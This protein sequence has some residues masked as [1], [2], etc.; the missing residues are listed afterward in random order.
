MEC[1]IIWTTMEWVIMEGF[2]IPKC[3]R[4]KEEKERQPKAKQKIKKRYNKY[5]INPSR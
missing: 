2:Q 1:L 3:H 4:Q 5:E